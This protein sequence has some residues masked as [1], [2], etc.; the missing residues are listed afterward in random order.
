MKTLYPE[1]K[2]LN[3]D[4]KDVSVK[5]DVGDNVYYQVAYVKV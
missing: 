3:I 5:I 2:V 1:L 4:D